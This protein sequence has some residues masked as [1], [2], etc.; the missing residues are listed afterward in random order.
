[1]KGQI[2]KTVN[3]VNHSYKRI[4]RQ[5]GSA[6]IIS[7]IILLAMTLI[8]VQGM[9][10]TTLEEKMSG[11]YLDNQIA[12]E[13]AESALKAASRW[14]DDRTTAP[15]VDSSGT[16]GVWTYGVPQPFSDTWWSSNG[17][18]AGSDMGGLS[19]QSLSAQPMYYIEFRQKITNNSPE[20]GSLAQPPTYFYLITARGQGGLA[21]SVVLLQ[22]SFA[23]QY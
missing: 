7:L 14:L 4:Y 12:F 15:I 2:V 3:K 22:E 11:N 19:G 9:R 1:M 13:A 10:T 16:N 21:N 5:R 23:K 8:G 17:T 20:I 18:S 6:L